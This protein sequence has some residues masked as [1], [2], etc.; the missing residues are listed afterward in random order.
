MDTLQA[1]LSLTAMPNPPYL[2]INED[3]VGALLEAARLYPAPATRSCSDAMGSSCFKKVIRL[4][5]KKL[6]HFLA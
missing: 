6:M 5:V 3:F 1:R 4:D 2:L